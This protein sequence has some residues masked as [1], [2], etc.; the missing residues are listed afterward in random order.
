MRD[1]YSNVKIENILNPGIITATTTSAAI[2]VH[3]GGDALGLY[4]MFGAKSGAKTL[5][6]GKYWD[7]TVTESD[8]ASGTFTAV[9]NAD[10]QKTSGEG[11]VGSIAYVNADGELSTTH[12]SGYRGNKEYI[13]VV[14]TLTG[15]GPGI[16]VAVVGV[17][18]NL[19]IRPVS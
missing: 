14:L 10:L 2:Q 11:A 18:G 4:V 7:V 16:N 8:T 12:G 5:S 17:R 19:T 6:S 9:A 1:I 15:D 3:K 13:K